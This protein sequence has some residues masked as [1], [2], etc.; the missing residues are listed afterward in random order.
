[1]P[2]LVTGLG[3][4]VFFLL[5]SFSGLLGGYAALVFCAVMVILLHPEPCQFPSCDEHFLS[6]AT[7]FVIHQPK[8]RIVMLL[9]EN[10]PCNVVEASGQDFH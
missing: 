8:S 7:S 9:T 10:L 5:L 4:S 6:L 2:I 3:N 1:M